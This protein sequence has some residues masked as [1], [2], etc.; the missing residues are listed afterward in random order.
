MNSEE[1]VKKAVKNDWRPMELAVGVWQ[2]RPLEA[3]NLRKLDRLQTLQTTDWIPDMALIRK[4]SSGD[5]IANTKVC[6]CGS[7]DIQDLFML[8]TIP[9]R[10]A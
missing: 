10:G 3:F 8:C 2:I 7:Y 9:Y 1:E 6:I 4:S 5:A